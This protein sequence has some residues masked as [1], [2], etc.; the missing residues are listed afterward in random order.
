MKRISRFLIAL[1]AA[2]ILFQHY[3]HGNAE[4]LDWESAVATMKKGA[5]EMIEGRKL[6]QQ[7]KDPASAEKMIKDGHRVMMN[8]EKDLIKAQ[9]GLMRQG[10][11]MMMDGLKVL[12]TKNDTGDAEKI[13]ARGQQMILEADKMMADT[14]PEKMMQGSRTMMRG[15]RM[16]QEKDLKTAD[17]LMTEGEGMMRDPEQ[18]GKDKN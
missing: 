1:I 16:R 4:S 12:Q 8:A 9:N 2:G 17:R 15:L 10:A 11:K 5:N 7:K 13:M 18:E 3:T 14:R 6:M